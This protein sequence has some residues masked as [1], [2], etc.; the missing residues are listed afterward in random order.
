MDSAIAQ[1]FKAM[2]QI[3]MLFVHTLVWLV[4]RLSISSSNA[5][6]TAAPKSCLILFYT[7]AEKLHTF[8]FNLTDRAHTVV[9]YQTKWRGRVSNVE[10]KRP[11]STNNS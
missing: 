5:I 7:P 8:I 6:R 3:G 2:L 11:F 10:V 4:T 9:S 1:V